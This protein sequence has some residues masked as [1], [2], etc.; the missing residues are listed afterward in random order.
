MLGLVSKNTM[1]KSLNKVNLQSFFWTHF[2]RQRTREMGGNVVPFMQSFIS[3]RRPPGSSHRED[4]E[5]MA[6]AATKPFAI[7]YLSER[8]NEIRSIRGQTYFGEVGRTIDDILENYPGLRWWMTKEGLVIDTVPPDADR[9]SQ[10]DSKAGKL[11]YESMQNGK[12]PIDVVYQIS[13][14]LDSTG[15]TLRENLQPAQWKPIAD[16]N[17]RYSKKAI[18]S[19]TEA[20]SN[21]RFVRPIRRRFYVA[22]DRYQRAY[23]SNPS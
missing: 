19:F 7:A 13:A 17:Q 2:D 3:L 18:R 1:A 12:L 15:F 4:I 16:Y 21:P 23:G 11:V 8:L 10:F 20:V 14:E 6:D 22:R 5:Q 9:L